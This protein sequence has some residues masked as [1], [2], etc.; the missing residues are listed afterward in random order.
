MRA[1]HAVEAAEERLHRTQARAEDEVQRERGRAGVREEDGDARE[2]LEAAVE[3]C[4]E[5]SRRGPQ[6][7]RNRVEEGEQE[8][9]EEA[10]ELVG[11]EIAQLSSPFLDGASRA[12]RD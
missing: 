12:A 3:A 10:E 8:G 5:R 7:K 4:T 11:G 2:R 1:I 6:R 9:A